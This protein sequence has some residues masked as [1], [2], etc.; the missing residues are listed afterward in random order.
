MNELIINMSSQIEQFEQQHNV[1]LFD[2]ERILQ[3]TQSE[4]SAIDALNAIDAFN[5]HPMELLRDIP[6]ILYE[7]K[8]D[9][10]ERKFFS[11]LLERIIN[12]NIYNKSFI[13]VIFVRH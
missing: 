7:L 10:P 6:P 5:I 9:N 11:Q 8:E 3:L 2:D 4:I 12:F 13:S 1:E